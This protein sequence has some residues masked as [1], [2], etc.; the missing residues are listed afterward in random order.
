MYKNTKQ[1]TDKIEEMPKSPCRRECTQ[2]IMPF[3]KDNR[4]T[5]QEQVPEY[6]YACHHPPV[7]GSTSPRNVPTVDERFP[8]TTHSNDT[9]KTNTSRV[10]LCTCVNFVTAA[11]GP[12]TP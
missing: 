6:H 8:A 4:V 5:Y 2:V 9:F 1:E 10:I 3:V 12:K 11:T 7:A